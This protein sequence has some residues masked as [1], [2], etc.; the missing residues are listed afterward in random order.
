MLF[1]PALSRGWAVPGYYLGHERQ[2]TR[3]A[4]LGAK[5]RRRGCLDRAE[6]VGDEALVVHRLGPDRPAKLRALCA[7]FAARTRSACRLTHTT[8]RG[9]ACTWKLLPQCT[10][11]CGTAGPVPIVYRRR[12]PSSWRRPTLCSWNVPQPMHCQTYAS[13][14]QTSPTKQ[15]GCQRPPHT[16]RV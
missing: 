5:R 14:L 11:C 16:K 8:W 7:L 15:P 9:V 10:Q 3:H 13:L 2:E 1:S 4:L 12:L 6:K